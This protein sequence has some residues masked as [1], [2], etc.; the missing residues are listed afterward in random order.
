[1]FCQLPVRIDERG[2]RWRREAEFGNVVQLAVTQGHSR[3]QR[4]N[5]VGLARPCSAQE[6]IRYP[7]TFTQLRGS[8]GSACLNPDTS[9]S[10]VRS[11]QGGR[12][13]TQSTAL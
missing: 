12:S 1:M 9:R 10:E 7:G 4:C 2:K 11:L 13:V 6:I 5:A 3:V 8:W